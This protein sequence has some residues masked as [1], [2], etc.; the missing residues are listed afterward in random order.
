MLSKINNRSL[1]SSTEIVY[2]YN[3]FKIEINTLFNFDFKDYKH[4]NLGEYK[5]RREPPFIFIFLFLSL[6]HDCNHVKHR[7]HHRHYH[8]SDD[9]RHE[10]N[11]YRLY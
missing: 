4:T 8:K 10:Y 1:Y 9:K 6:S 5:R 7:H 2:N 3:E 11:H